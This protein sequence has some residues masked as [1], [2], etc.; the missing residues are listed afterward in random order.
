MQGVEIFGQPAE[1][2]AAGSRVSSIDSSFLSTYN[3][4]SLAAALQARTPLYIKSY[5]VSGISSVSFRGTMASHTAVLWN[6]LN[7][8]SP[9]LGQ[10]DLAA[11][12][13]GGVGTIAIQHGGTGAMYGSGAIGGAILLTSPDYTSQGF[14]G[15]L[16]QEAGSF[17]RYYSKATFNYGNDKFSVSA[18]GYR[19]QAENDFRYTDYASFGA[20]ERKQEHAAILQYGFTQDLAWNLSTNSK[21]ALHSW[22]TFADREPQAS[23]GAAHNNSRQ[24][25]KNLRLLAEYTLG[26]NW[27]ETSIKA[28][29]FND[30]LKYTA[31]SINSIAD[32]ATY[33]LQA[34]Q[35]YTYGR[36][37]RLR[38]GI[39]LQHFAA[40]VDGYS[41]PEKE[42]RA[43]AF[44]LLRYDPI[45]ALAL[46]LNLRQAFAEGYNPNPTPTLGAN[47]RFYSNNNHLFYLKGN[48]AGSYR[49]PTLNDRFWQP[50]G[51]PDLKSEQGWNYETGLQ[52]EY[53]SGTLHLESEA[54]VYYM[55]VD[56]WVQW[57]PTEQGFYTPKNLQ[58]VRSQGIEI[59]SSATKQLGKVSITAATGYTYTLSEQVKSYEGPEELHKQL[60]YVPLHKATGALSAAWQNWSLTG[61]VSYN[62]LR[63]TTSDNTTNLA[64]FTL[65]DLAASRKF[66]LGSNTLQAS[67]QA[68][69]LLNTEYQTME[70]MPMP[71]RNYA[72][73]FRFIIP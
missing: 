8:S 3:S 56:N 22:Y 12:P 68:N 57:V 62:G 69:N 38:G 15:E 54:T 44:V 60:A 27:G 21:L 43:S 46:S 48:V 72:I 49:V 14:S 30:L 7:I 47:Y 9:S 35:T 37:W 16:Q 5:G 31:T 61:N 11:L 73:N 19:L 55:L 26:T 66:I 1:I 41:Q 24:I 42:N 39:N 34:E 23:L 59:S 50:G 20:P 67:V 52:H 63:Y 32:I 58:K 29:Y 28:G 2:Y 64:A 36:T 13:L 45:E 51:N 6:G 17:G 65:L 33:Q 53:T 70:N 71:G 25:D 10:T 18:G 4:T 40:N